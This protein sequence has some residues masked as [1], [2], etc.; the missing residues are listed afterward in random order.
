MYFCTF[1]SS[2]LQYKLAATR[3]YLQLKEIDSIKKSYLIN[4][5]NFFSIIKNNY[6]LLYDN[7]SS[8]K[9]SIGFAFWAWKPII[10][11]HI[12]EKIPESSILLYADVGCNLEKNE[13]YWKKF[14]DRV[15]N[16]NLITANSVGFG[17]KTYG[18]QERTWTKP[19]IFNSLKLEEIHQRT[20]QYQATWIAIKKNNTNLEMIRSWI[21]Y[22]TKDNFY[23][24]RPESEF[25][26][27]NSNFI[28]NRADQSVFSCLLKSRSINLITA[29]SE[30]MEN[31]KASR[32]LSIFRFYGNN[33]PLIQK[34]IKKLERGFVKIFNNI[35]YR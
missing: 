35:I 12:L 24:V 28:S 6:P 9:K 15:N 20:S 11:L 3:L 30:D 5:N 13:I 21:E 34:I 31:I 22:C 8:E 4:E 26:S 23:L 14:L 27:A 33:L 2:K 25:L 29:N 17:V 7:F 32:N 19:E 10:I 1:Y 16:H 18:A